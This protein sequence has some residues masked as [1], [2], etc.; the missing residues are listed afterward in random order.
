MFQNAAWDQTP[1]V[2]SIREDGTPVCKECGADLPLLQCL[3]GA[4]YCPG[5]G[6][7]EEYNRRKKRRSNN[8]R[9]HHCKV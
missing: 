1:G 7:E 8:R 3:R 9:N 2:Q 5:S 6:C 4:L